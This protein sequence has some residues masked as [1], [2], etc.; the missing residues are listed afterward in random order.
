MAEQKKVKLV[1]FMT[2]VSARLF[3]SQIYSNNK[4]CPKLSGREVSAPSCYHL[5]RPQSPWQREGHVV[6]TLTP[7][8]SAQKQQRLHLLREVSG[9][10]ESLPK[11]AM[12]TKLFALSLIFQGTQTK[13]T[14]N[15]KFSSCE[16]FRLPEQNFEQ[17][18][19]II[20]F[21]S[22]ESHVD[23]SVKEELQKSRLMLQQP[24][25]REIQQDR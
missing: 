13:H 14:Q 23:N 10:L 3:L 16:Q 8:A 7:K 12:H 11:L 24:V 9:S 18:S 21:V 25:R 15:S 17:K 20:I 5:I 2:S 4:Q 19:D 6:E 22:K 1:S